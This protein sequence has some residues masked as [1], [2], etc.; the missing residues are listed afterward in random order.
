MS[1]E[2]TGNKV[3]TIKIHINLSCVIYE[4]FR[5]SES[6]KVGISYAKIENFCFRFSISVW[7]NESLG[8]HIFNDFGVGV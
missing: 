4:I 8:S 7:V 6:R 2:N 3:D 1:L 5:R